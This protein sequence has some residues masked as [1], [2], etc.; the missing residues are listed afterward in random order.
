MTEPQP[1]P[2]PRR[3]PERCLLS[4]PAGVEKFWAKAAQSAADT[5]MLDLEDAVPPGEKDAAR[6]MAVR[7]CNEVDWGRRTLCVRING[8]DTRWA[9]RDLIGLA[10][11]CPRLDT[12]MVPKIERPEEVVAVEVWLRGVELA[13]GRSRPI[14]IEGQIENALGLTRVEAIAAASPRLESI[15]Y[16]P[17]D[18]AASIGNKAPIIGGPDPDYTV[19][20]AP[21]GQAGPQTHWND[22]WHYAMARI[23][24]ACR[25][26]G[27]RALD[28]PYVDFQHPE[29]F[30][31]A[32]RRA[33]SLGYTGKW[34]IH[35]D[36]IELANRVFSPSHEEVAQ[37]R[38]VLEAMEQA[39]RE[40]R[41]AISLDGQMLDMAHVRQAQSI[42]A[43]ADLIAGETPDSGSP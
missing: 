25:A 8:L 36:Q 27:V 14:G 11:N 41:G 43:V 1:L 38:R 12:V 39:H 15:S 28:G 7:A 30:L 24:V 29:G 4:L 42:V 37:A 35:P 17:G 19:L 3:R 10:E 18:Y 5:V 34:A 20:T 40:G 21:D 22:A 32:A 23:A 13:V 9:Y 2:P 31:S 6:A 33:R 16:G 26:H